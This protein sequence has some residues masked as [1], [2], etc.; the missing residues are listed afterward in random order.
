MIV[1]IGNKTINVEMY[2]YAKVGDTENMAFK[3]DGEEC[4]DFQSVINKVS[5]IL[6][7]ELDKEYEN[8]NN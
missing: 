8:E 6:F 7:D 1:K 4:M 3:V 2:C 5:D